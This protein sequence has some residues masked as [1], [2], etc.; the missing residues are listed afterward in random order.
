MDDLLLTLKRT[1]GYSTFRPLQREIIDA[2]LA[3]QDVFALLPTG[4][5][6]S[7]CFQLPALARPGL[8][9]VV[10][11]LIALMK[12][13]VD[14]L[15]ASG[16]AATFLNS[17]LSADESRSR[18]RGL[19]RG[20]YKLLY[21]APERLMLEGWVENLKAWNVTCLAIDEAHC[22]SE[23]G[24][25]FR[26]EYRQLVRLRKALPN[27]PLMALTATATGRVREDI[28]NH[29]Q[30]RNPATF[31]ASFNRPNLT[32]RVIPKDQPLKQIIDFVRPRETES[33]IIYCASRAATERVAEALSGRGFS[34]R[35]YH[36]GLPGD[37]RATNQEAFLRDDTRI[38]CATIA[39]GMGINKPNVRWIIHH[40]LPKNIEGYYQETGRAGRDG[41][42]GDCLLLFSAGDIAKQTHFLDE[43]TN[44]Q[45]Q[46]VAR[47][48]LR[49][50]V[51]YAESSG[52]RRA[53]L[54]AYFGETFPLDNCGACDN[55]LEPRD[56]YDGTLA[57][58]KFL[59][60]VYRVAQNSR[61]GVGMNHLIEVLTGAATEKI[62]RWGHDRLT[63]YGIGKEFSRPQWS[64]VGREL[65]RLGFVTVAEGEYATL[66]LTDE[67]MALLRA[68]TSVTLTRP[69]DLPKARRVPRRE[70]DIACDE[71][72]FE[73]LRT[74][75]KQLADERKVP[76]YIVFGDTT[77][78]AMARF[79][80]AS[81]SAMEGIPGI[82][83]K[84]RAEFGAPF[85]AAI[86]DYLKT[87]SQQ[88]F[89]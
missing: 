87:N 75:R 60:C 50:I 3:G 78:R 62:R 86:A 9:V 37:E 72:L 22:V 34:A 52:C 29:L 5:G 35:A 77:L 56:T 59:S 64:A 18:L 80:P 19:H 76:A 7:L 39:F 6:K 32:Y 12:D 47:A 73:R 58:Q 20:E 53:E 10:S 88:A 44:E 41:L 79:Y 65:M 8:T 74:L 45:E 38:I 89:D 36:A 83:E 81:P 66:Q 27:V 28:V 61:F 25:D 14:A 54:L 70:G 15:Q 16:V 69:M 63:T 11:P 24:H 23:W 42:P 85:A 67:G 43:I 84:K 13:Q 30:L 57:A 48:Q 49:Q 33:G 51:H 40:D 71:I 21:A 2:T 17:T 68:R 82:G 55:C 1:F 31:V 4:G 46:Q 26:P